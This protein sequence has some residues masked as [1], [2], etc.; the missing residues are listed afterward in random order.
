MRIP[1]RATAAA[2]VCLACAA[3][4]AVRASALRADH[5]AQQQQQQQDLQME[6]PLPAADLV[7]LNGRVLTM[8]T[9]TP[10]AQAIAIR[11]D[12]IYVVGSNAD[13]RKR[14]GPS[15]QT[16]DLHGQ[17]AIPGFIES[18]GH[19]A[20]VGEM[21]EELDLTKAKSWDD[22]VAMVGEAATKARRDATPS[23]PSGLPGG[24]SS[25]RWIR[26]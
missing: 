20:G 9:A 8:E 22:I 21:K 11:D 3:V 23:S 18:H 10:E 4:L 5:P 17:L 24:T 19:F 26:A 1:M 25:L 7:L 14:I 13:V 12:S 16:I 2:A 6:T 15:T